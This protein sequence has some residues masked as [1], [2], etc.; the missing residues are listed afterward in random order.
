MYTNRVI[1]RHRM[2][3]SHTAYD[4]TLARK[5]EDR[6]TARVGRT[7][8]LTVTENRVRMVSFRRDRDLVR[9]RV[10][11][12]FLYAPGEVIDALAGWIDSPKRGVPEQVREFVRGIEA[13][14][15]K[16]APIQP[17]PSFP[18][19][20]PGKDGTL[21]LPLT[22]PPITDAHPPGPVRTKGQYHDLTPLA[23]NVNKRF[24][25]GRITAAITWGRDT[26]RN[27]AR[28]R[29]LGSY[30]PGQNLIVIHPV[31][32]HKDVPEKVVAFIVYH[33]ML[34]ALQPP[35]RGSR[36]HD[37]AFRE[38]ERA[39]PD[40]EWVQKWQEKH[41]KLIHGGRR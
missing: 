23:D 35:L 39:H 1:V 21:P 5:L 22:P 13:R 32:D 33:E 9:L 41:R 24:F 3:S 12:R 34:H 36:H 37:K 20:T 11:L 31:L 27:R 26:S 10:H 2:A 30:R 7:V 15:A 4:F 19:L 28:T 8:H 40:Y 18:P 38:K 25:Q 29:R 17:D 16:R 6:L 14:P